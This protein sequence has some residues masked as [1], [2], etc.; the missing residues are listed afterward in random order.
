MKTLIL[1]LFMSCGICYGQYPEP[2]VYNFQYPQTNVYYTPVVVNYPV[3]V[4]AVQYVPVVQ[5]VVVQQPVM[6]NYPGN[7]PIVYVTDRFYRRPCWG[8]Y[9]R[10]YQY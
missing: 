7:W 1:V 10:A 8:Q 6:V 5:N 9:Y 4:Q 3:V 2:V